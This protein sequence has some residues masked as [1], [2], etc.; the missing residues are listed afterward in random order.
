MSRPQTSGG[1]PREAVRCGNCDELAGPHFCPHCGQE[2]DAR[3]G[4][5]WAVGREFLSDWLSLDSQLL[6][7][8]R[9]LLRP[10]RLSELYLSGKRAPFLRPFR[11]YLVASLVLFSTVLT[12][13]TPDVAEYDIILGGQSIGQASTEA[14]HARQLQIGSETATVRK[15]LDLL[16]DQTTLGRLTIH[17]AGDRIERVQALPPEQAVEMLFTGLRR[18][19]PLT[20]ILFVP[21]LALGLKLLY[22]RRRAL[23]HL[24]LDHLVFAVHFQSALFFGL[25][26]TWLIGRLARFELP[27]NLIAAVVA[28]VALIWVYLPFALRKFYRQSRLWTGLK[29]LAVLYLYSELL[30]LIISVSAL[31]GIWGV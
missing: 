6:R 23:H 24:Y 20:L 21:L 9:A 11:L 30:S 17:L 31:V 3:H 12:L 13:D 25:S 26:A 22:I 14:N 27:G 18:T 7:S 15:S 29:T 4:P 28:I 1:Q 16:N 19:L 8:L 5:L 10:A 2:V